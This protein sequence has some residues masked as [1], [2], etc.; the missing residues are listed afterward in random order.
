MSLACLGIL[1]GFTCHRPISVLGHS[2]TRFSLEE[3]SIPPADTAFRATATS[4]AS[5]AEQV[6]GVAREQLVLLFVFSFFWQVF[7]GIY[8]VLLGISFDM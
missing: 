8:S 7:R 6:F 2:E 5:A 3:P 1:E 4:I